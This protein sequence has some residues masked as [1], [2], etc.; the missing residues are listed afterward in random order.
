MIFPGLIFMAQP[1]KEVKL[2][3]QLIGEWSVGIAMKTND[4]RVVS[5]CGNMTAKE[6]AC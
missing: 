2:L 3:K 1:F 6:I 4:D 5:G